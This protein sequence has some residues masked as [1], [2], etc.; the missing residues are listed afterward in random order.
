MRRHPHAERGDET[1]VADRQYSSLLA[2]RVAVRRLL[3][4]SREQGAAAGLTPAPH[5]LLLVVHT[6]PDPRG[7]T[8][9]RLAALLLVRHHSAVQLVDRVEAEGLVRRR[10]DGEDRRLVRVRLTPAGARRL[11]ALGGVHAEELRHLTVLATAAAELTTTAAADP[12]P[13]PAPEPGAR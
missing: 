2:F 8:I 1:S 6:H 13:G 3:R 10:R 11:A 4:W 12:D 5:Q 7:P 9:G